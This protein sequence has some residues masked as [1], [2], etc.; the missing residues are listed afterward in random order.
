MVL[1]DH[2]AKLEGNTLDTPEFFLMLCRNGFTVT[3]MGYRRNPRSNENSAPMSISALV[4]A[5]VTFVF[6]LCC[7]YL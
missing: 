1:L 5:F 4:V 3:Q 6:G 2:V 7:V